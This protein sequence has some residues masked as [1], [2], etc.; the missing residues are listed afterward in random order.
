MALKRLPL[1]L[2]IVWIALG[3]GLFSLPQIRFE[4]LPWRYPEVAECFTE[5]VSA[6]CVPYG[7]TEI[8]HSHGLLAVFV[9]APAFRH[10]HHEHD[11]TMTCTG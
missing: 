8:V 10:S 2:P 1:S 4:R 11:L 6:I 5:F 3:A 7:L 9:T